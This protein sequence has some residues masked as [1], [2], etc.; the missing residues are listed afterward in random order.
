MRKHRWMQWS[1]L[2]PRRP[3]RVDFIGSPKFRSL[4]DSLLFKFDY[5]AC[6]VSKYTFNSDKS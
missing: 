5:L 2:D 4:D 3:A 1:Y 6:S